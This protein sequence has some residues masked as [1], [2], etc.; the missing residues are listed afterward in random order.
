MTNDRAAR[1]R[2]G[3]KGTY[4]VSD[5]LLRRP[6]DRPHV[7][8][9]R[10]PKRAAKCA[11]SSGESSVGTESA[12]D[13]VRLAGSVAEGVGSGNAGSF[14]VVLCQRREVELLNSR[15]NRSKKPLDDLFRQGLAH[16]HDV[17]FSSLSRP[18]T[19]QRPCG[20]RRPLGTSLCG[21]PVAYCLYG[22]EHCGSVSK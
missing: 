2:A 8:F 9:P 6:R 18:V 19:K 1:E 22:S 17:L 11:V 10:P 4:Q 13:A 7:L 20:Y 15:R 12:G 16:D 14:M 21:S 5:R 3:E